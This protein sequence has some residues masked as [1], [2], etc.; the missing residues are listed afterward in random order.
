MLAF[1]RKNPDPELASAYQRAL[2][3]VIADDGDFVIRIDQ[4]DEEFDAWIREVGGCTREWAIITP[5]NPRSRR[6]REELNGFYFNEL[7]F[8]IEAKSGNWFK[9]HNVDPTGDWKDEPGFLMI[10]PDIRW[11]MDLGRKCKQNALVACRLGETQ[12]LIWL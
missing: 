12:R 7:R 4:F 8:T 6:A 5:C 9:V 2:Y 11:A 10:D 3:R 1:L